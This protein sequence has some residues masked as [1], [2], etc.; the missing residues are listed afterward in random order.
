MRASHVRIDCTA[1]SAVSLVIPTLLR[2]DPDHRLAICLRHN[3][4]CVDVLELRIAIGT[5]SAFVGLAIVLAREAKLHEFLAYRV[6]ADGMSHPLST[7][8]SLSMLF[9]TQIS[10]RMGWPS[11]AG[12]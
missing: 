10:G 3:D 2:V 4:F 11:V 1:N 7:P 6:G 9:E 12:S 8:A 5:A